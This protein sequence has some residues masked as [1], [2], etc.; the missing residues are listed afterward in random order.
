MS[1][2]RWWWILI[3]LFFAGTATGLFLE[4]FFAG[5][6]KEDVDLRQIE[7]LVQERQLALNNML[8]DFSGQTLEDTELLWRK[9]D[10]VS[11]T[12][13][14]VLVFRNNQLIAWS[15]QA[16]PVQELHPVFLMQPFI[17]LENGYYLVQQIR[18]GPFF[19]GWAFQNKAVVSLSE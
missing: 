3:I 19:A 5:A 2:K 8:R 16:I 18:R 11:Q 17:K 14:D 9:M 12:G 10:S 1:G 6:E 4:F 13:N 7:Q 15:N